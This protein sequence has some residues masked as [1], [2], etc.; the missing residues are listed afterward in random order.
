MPTP[1]VPD[2]VFIKV[3]EALLAIVTTC[4]TGFL[5]FLW[6]KYNGLYER[7]EKLERDSLPKDELRST[8]Q[9]ILDA[10]HRVEDNVI[11][12]VDRIEDEQQK[13]SIDIAV[14]KTTVDL[15][16]PQCPPPETSH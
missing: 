12:R 13:H 2:E 7:L 10:I 6:K 4:A 8:R 5:S 11:E 9:E 1:V 14:L 15:K 3:L 16:A